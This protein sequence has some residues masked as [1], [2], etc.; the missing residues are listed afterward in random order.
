MIIASKGTA[1]A[2]HTLGRCKTR[3]RASQYRDKIGDFIGDFLDAGIAIRH[4][5]ATL[6]RYSTFSNL[7]WNKHLARLHQSGKMPARRETWVFR[8]YGFSD[9]MVAHLVSYTV[10]A[11]QGNTLTTYPCVWQLG[12]EYTNG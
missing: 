6:T 1:A 3:N 9:C 4:D 5:F 8:L 10:G 12:I 11:F 2:C 7:L